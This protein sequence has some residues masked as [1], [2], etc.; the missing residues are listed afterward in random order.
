MATRSVKRG[1]ASVAAAG[2]LVSVMAVAAPGAAQASVTS[3]RG[4]T[5]TIYLSKSETRALGNG[6]VPKLPSW[7]PWQ[8]KGSYYSLAYGHK[9][10]AKQYS[11]RGMCSAFTLSV[12]PGHRQ[13][14]WGYKCNWK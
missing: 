5:C 9:W 13:G 2:V 3:C 1:A 10:F 11:N 14:Y 12:W 6:K 8:I 7:A 4:G